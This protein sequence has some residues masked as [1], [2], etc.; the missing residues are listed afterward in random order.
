MIIGR[1]ELATLI[2]HS[3]AMC[4]LDSVVEWNE[5]RI[6]CRSSTHRDLGNP[7]RRADG[8]HA[9]CG[10]EYVSQA[11]AAHAALGKAGKDR[12]RKGYLASVRRFEMSLSRLDK[13]DE[14]LDIEAEKVIAEAQRALYH[15]QISAAG[16]VLLSGRAAVAFEVGPT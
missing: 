3:G 16:R 7:L 11:M 8:L 15:F 6:R 14:D 4:L 13:I 2:P 10:I 12:P 1:R 9:V 5:F